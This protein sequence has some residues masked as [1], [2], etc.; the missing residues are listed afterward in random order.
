MKIED[1]TNQSHN[2]KITNYTD[3]TIKRVVDDV[4]SNINSF[5]SAKIDG[6]AGVLNVSGR[7]VQKALGIDLRQLAYQSERHSK[8]AFLHKNGRDNYSMG[9]TK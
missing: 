3:S 7:Q 8:T 9:Y 6:R 1:I 5:G 4:R 2:S